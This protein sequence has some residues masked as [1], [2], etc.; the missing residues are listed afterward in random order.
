MA[1]TQADLISYDR[2]TEI[3][4]VNGRMLNTVVVKCL[5][6]EMLPYLDLGKQIRPF[7]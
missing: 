4:T 7:L 2:I 3:E 1:A 6:Q 5:Q